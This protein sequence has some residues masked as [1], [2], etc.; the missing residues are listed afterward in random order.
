MNIS[1][2]SH[3]L[4][5]RGLKQR[6][7]KLFLQV[8]NVARSTRAWIETS[9]IVST[10]AAP[11]VARSTRAWIETMIVKIASVTY[12]VARSTRAWI[13]TPAAF[14]AGRTSAGRTLYACVD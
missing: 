7:I 5:V 3:A 1:L 12:N 4:R 9:P 11:A 6:L 2:P 13:E 14:A 8:G 10:I